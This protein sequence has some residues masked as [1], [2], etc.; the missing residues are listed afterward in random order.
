VGE[1][2]ARCTVGRDVGGAHVAVFVG[3]DVSLRRRW[4]GAGTPLTLAARCYDRYH[5]GRAASRRVV[6]EWDGPN[7]EW[8]GSQVG[9]TAWKEYP[10]RAADDPDVGSRWGWPQ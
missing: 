8:R 3:L 5:A 6:A 7:R 10:R 9:P 4:V 2:G 1:E